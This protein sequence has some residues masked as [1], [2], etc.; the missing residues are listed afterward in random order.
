MGH[1]FALLSKSKMTSRSRIFLFILSWKIFRRAVRKNVQRFRF[2]ISCTKRQQQQKIKGKRTK[3]VPRNVSACLFWVWPSVLVSGFQ[4]PK[5]NVTQGGSKLMCGIEFFRRWV[6][7]ISFLRRN[8]LISWLTVALGLSDEPSI[9]L[10][11][12]F[13]C[14]AGKLLQAKISWL[15]EMAHYKYNQH[16]HCIFVPVNI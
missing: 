7:I 1:T 5:S 4:F 13:T 15:S 10:L 6:Y 12:Q 2:Y 14:R 8:Q 11:V 16:Q 9:H 3:R